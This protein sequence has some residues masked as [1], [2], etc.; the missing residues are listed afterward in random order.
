M[1]RKINRI[2]A[3]LLVSIMFMSDAIA[4][5]SMLLEGYDSE[6]IVSTDYS[7]TDSDHI[8]EETETIDTE[9]TETEITEELEHPENGLGI[10]PFLDNIIEVTWGTGTTGATF[11]EVGTELRIHESQL[12][13]TTNLRV[14]GR[15]DIPIVNTM[16]WANLNVSYA[17]AV[18]TLAVGA[19]AA[20]P[21][22]NPGRSMPVN[23]INVP[24]MDA[25]PF[26]DIGGGVEEAAITIN[27]S[28]GTHAN[29]ATAWGVNSTANS[30][31]LIIYRDGGSGGGPVE[32]T[33]SV[34][35]AINL[36]PRLQLD[37]VAPVVNW[38]SSNPNVARVDGNGVVVGVSAGTATITVTDAADPTNYRSAEITVTPLSANH[39]AMN[40]A[41]LNFAQTALPN[42]IPS[43]M[44]FVVAREEV[45]FYA[46]VNMEAQGSLGAIQ[47][48][49]VGWTMPTL[50]GWFGN[51]IIAGT[52]DGF[53]TGVSISDFTRYDSVSAGMFRAHF[54]I[55][56]GTVTFAPGVPFETIYIYP[57][58]Q[59]ASWGAGFQA[60]QPLE[61]RVLNP[62]FGVVDMTAINLNHNEFTLVVSDDYDEPMVTTVQLIATT[63]PN[64]P[65]IGDLA[66][67]SSDTSI[68]TVDQS[69]LVTGVG[70]GTATIAVRSLQNPGVQ[71]TMEVTV[72]GARDP[73]VE[74]TGITLAPQTATLILGDEVEL[75]SPNAQPSWWGTPNLTHPMWEVQT[76]TDLLQPKI[77][78]EWV[79][80]RAWTAA[81]WN[82]IPTSATNWQDNWA[83]TGQRG[84]TIHIPHIGATRVSMIYSAENVLQP[85][86]FSTAPNHNPDGI[87]RFFST[88]NT[89]A[90]TFI[91]AL[92]GAGTIAEGNFAAS[93]AGGLGM[94]G[95]AQGFRT[96]FQTFGYLYRVVTFTLTP[97]QELRERVIAE[98]PQIVPVQGLIPI[99]VPG[100][101]A[102]W[103]PSGT[104][105]TNTVY[106]IVSED[107]PPIGDDQPFS[108]VITD[109]ASVRLQAQIQPQNATN[110]G[111]I[112]ESSD[113]SIATVVGGVVAG[114][115]PGV[116]TITV[117][118]AANPEIF[119]TSTITVMYPFV[120]ENTLPDRTITHQF[121]WQHSL[122][123]FAGGVTD[124]MDAFFYSKPDHL[125][126][127]TEEF[128][129]H[130]A[131][132]ENGPR[133]NGRNLDITWTS[134]NTSIVTVAN[135]TDPDRPERAI[136]TPVG[137]L[138]QDAA[139]G[140]SFATI[141][142]S[143]IVNGQIF[144]A[145]T[146]VR[147]YQP[148]GTTIVYLDNVSQ[149]GTVN[150][151][152]VEVLA[153]GSGQLT[154]NNVMDIVGRN[155]NLQGGPD[156]GFP[157]IRELYIIGTASV[158]SG[159]NANSFNNNNPNNPDQWFRGIGFD[160]NNPI[161]PDYTRGNLRR[162]VI[163]NT[164]SFGND[165]F[166]DS[167]S[168]EY[169]YTRH[170]RSMG[171]RVI[172]MPQHSQSSRLH[173]ARHPELTHI[174]FRTWY[175]NSVLSTLELG[176][177]ALH[178]ERPAA[179]AGLWFSF[180]SLA[181]I[182]REVWP[183]KPYFMTVVVPDYV[184]F[185]NFTRMEPD[186]NNPGPFLQGQLSEEIPWV[187]LPF[188]TLNRENLPEI[189]THPPYDDSEYDWLQEFY[190]VDL[191]FDDRQI[192]ISLNFFTFAQHLTVQNAWWRPV[193][194]YYGY[195]PSLG[196]DIDAF[197]IPQVAGQP[198][199][200]N[201]LTILDVMLWAKQVGYEGL[202]ITGYYLEGYQGMR[203]QTEAEK[204][205]MLYQ[206]R[207]IRRFAE[208]L[209]M[210]I[211]GTGFGNSFTDANP[212]R[213]EMDIER[214][215]FFLE[216]ADAMG[217]PVIR[218][219]A[220]NTP[221]D[222][223]QLGW[224]HIIDERLVPAIVELS[225][226][227]TARGFDVQIGVQNHGDVISTE[228]QALYL[229]HKL[230]SMGITNVGLVQDTG[231]WRDYQSLQSNF[232]DWY[233]AINAT[234]PI[235]GNF[236]F[237]K[238]PAGA[239]TA[240]GWLDL[241]RVF[242]DIRLSGYAGS[243]P[244]ELLWGG[245]G[246]DN[247][248][249]LSPDPN[250]TLE[251]LAYWEAQFG[252][253]TSQ[254]AANEAEW[255]LGL[256][257][258]AERR[259]IDSNMDI[260]TILGED[261]TI[262]PTN[263]EVTSPVSGE[264]RAVYGAGRLSDP[265]V[266]SVTVEVNEL[267]LEDIVAAHEGATVSMYSNA[268]FTNPQTTIALQGGINNVYVRVISSN[269]LMDDFPRD[270]DGNPTWEQAPRP[271]LD[272]GLLTV[273]R[274]VVEETFYLVQIEAPATE[275]PTT[276]APTTDEATTDES[277][278]EAPTTDE[279]TTDESTTEA[280]TTT[281]PTTTPPAGGGGGSG[282]GG[283][284]GGGGGSSRPTTPT[285]PATPSATTIA[286]PSAGQNQNDIFDQLD[287]LSRDTTQVILVLPDG[288]EEARLNTET[289]ERLVDDEVSLIIQKDILWVTLTPDF[290]DELN[291][292]GENFSVRITLPETDATNVF[293]LAEISFI[294]DTTRVVHFDTPYTIT[295]DMESFD[296]E[297]LNTNKIAILS[298]GKV[299]LG[300]FDLETGL[301]TA[302]V[303]HTGEFTVA[304]LP[305]LIVLEMST[306][307]N[308]I[309][310]LIY[311]NTTVMDVNP[312]VQNGRT[313][314]PI[315][316]IAEALGATVDWDGSTATATITKDGLR[317]TLVIGEIS[318]GMDVAAQII[319]NR[320]MVPL[321]YVAETL[322]ATVNW[323]AETGTIQI[324]SL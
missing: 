23:S 14:A 256:A 98:G 248:L 257:A 321:R 24:N 99:G 190:R 183:E 166:R 128:D 250:I 273:R 114:L 103:R 204:E 286:P 169:L 125:V 280:P 108:P 171:T 167:V 34:N 124:Y 163:Y 100:I 126:P 258:L 57:R 2:L 11:E 230:S 132:I 92:F 48:A 225:R 76:Y 53:T 254:N 173:T 141:T 72:L 272:S 323:A 264:T 51:E 263:R 153:I 136:L 255:F 82:A 15:T 158:P 206:A 194:E 176:W 105:P 237:K 38:I 296:L 304:Y 30:L 84:D 240:A 283:S 22:G 298:D 170:T 201:G 5:Q 285:A 160:P 50:A 91:P 111:L 116:V 314:V 59:H 242:R 174:T 318:Q 130:P 198:G 268:A 17:P 278:T 46:V 172:A 192:P 39:I 179:N 67:G 81:E 10:M 16:N 196:G 150:G 40:W 199:P 253:A 64:D 85:N 274:P 52:R 260:A 47:G 251:N 121:I 203:V 217:A 187:V 88:P 149:L 202:D 262:I 276:E 306:G 288:V 218:V 229:I 291:E 106:V 87:H 37:P 223:I 222:E 62:A 228:N 189:E 234:L 55:A 18:L 205:H 93:G 25:L 185:S 56:P 224:R 307:S 213:I 96:E 144:S 162:L 20:T 197:T 6:Y 305:E 316:F 43:P 4:A 200:P 302:D 115:A 66:W 148:N 113:P 312:I 86:T 156:A 157:N 177:D 168:L 129:D 208:L 241:D 102:D 104:F 284:G 49:G 65:T 133:A 294:A 313:L 209:E 180:S 311:D 271:G 297:N 41:Y 127:G 245:A 60:V 178:I 139:R 212:E 13:A 151:D 277:T 146:Q 1:K 303:D 9:E 74:V 281:P 301:F 227:A 101:Q 44:D 109:R 54:E 135:S 142:A 324:I 83:F 112:W 159:Q 89:G 249:H 322:G 315:R 26:V 214:Y 80:D 279:A 28:P 246:I 266:R 3:I 282:G 143:V 164:E 90:N 319:D 27:F 231:F 119:A 275:E 195:I 7:A 36:A 118:S 33:I 107:A 232:Y 289:L 69:G 235:S 191:P 154:N 207:E 247:D 70:N 292:R 155:R 317:A 295:V 182:M 123:L 63:I 32:E 293:A 131:R 265:R 95:D 226:Y 300:E 267:E 77:T 238:K 97:T 221:A 211:T 45:P 243:T 290:L 309:Q 42:I 61:I 244:I 145:D 181:D 137:I 308:L 252:R 215:K 184:A 71:A 233:H 78:L 110:Q 12:G 287:E 68:A 259:S 320:T 75:Y 193:E 140:Y 236:Q 161:N 269:G 122:D 239:G 188:A 220:G 29:A 19:G 299:I 219:F 152:I 310:E 79:T 8:T 138:P 270:A 175:Y 261:L 120:G 35:Q 58:P 94:I 117:R 165:F 134:S 21:T 216:I 147:V 186:E 31:T 210:E 73:D